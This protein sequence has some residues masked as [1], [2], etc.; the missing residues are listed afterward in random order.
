MEPWKLESSELIY[1]KDWKKQNVIQQSYSRLTCPSKVRKKLRHSQISKSWGILWLLVTTRPALQEMLRVILLGYSEK[2]LNYNLKP[3]EK[4]NVLVKI[5]ELSFIKVNRNVTLVCNF[6]SC[7]F[8]LIWERKY[9]SRS[10]K[11]K[12]SQK[13]MKPKKSIS[14][15]SI[16]KMAKIKETILKGAE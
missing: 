14:R 3:Y 1:S 5:T 15:H 4:I 7:F 10:K 16:I 11:H 9:I 13:K 2:I 6:T 12:E 8:V